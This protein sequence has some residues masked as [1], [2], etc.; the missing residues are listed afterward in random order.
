MTHLPSSVARKSILPNDEVVLYGAGR[1]GQDVF[2]VLN[3][4][5][6]PIVCFLDRSAASGDELLGLPVFRPQSCPL[7]AGD[8]RRLPLVLTIFNRDVDIP[9]LTQTLRELGFDRV[10]SFVD[11]HADFSEELGDRFWLTN[12]RYVMDHE[13]E[14]SEAETVWSDEASRVV[15]RSVVALRRSGTYSD[16]LAPSPHGT[17]Y[18]PSDIPEWVRQRPLRFVDCGAYNGDTLDAILRLRLPIGALAHFEP[19]P[20]NFRSLTRFVKDHR[21]EI[22][23]PVT[24][25]PC[26]VSNECQTVKFRVG[27][28]EGS[29]VSVDGEATVQTVALDDV[30]CGWGP[31]L[32]KMDIEGAEMDGLLG[33]KQQIADSRPNLAICIYHRPSHLWEIPLLLRGWKELPNYRYYVRV[34]G[35][36][37]FDTVLYGRPER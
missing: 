14:I 33:A 37:G 22:S 34:H 7:S 32:I 26:A 27:E 11:L 23:A 36:N 16:A 28:A 6:V 18:F 8:R 31:T 1:V 15:F 25:W 2:R 35:Y 13:R 9:A 17:Q 19:D 4:A 24:L 12:R 3:G 5:G 21:G 10:V 30:L 20:E 29:R